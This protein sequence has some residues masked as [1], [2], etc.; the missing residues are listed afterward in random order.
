[1]GPDRHVD[2]GGVRE[3]GKLRPYLIM[4]NYD[5]V[6]MGPDDVCGGGHEGCSVEIEKVRI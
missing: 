2:R 4:L 5:E 1:M 6:K 3:D